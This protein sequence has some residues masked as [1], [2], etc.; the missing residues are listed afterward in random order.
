MIAFGISANLERPAVSQKKKVSFRD[1][2]DVLLYACVAHTSEQIPDV[3]VVEHA[4]DVAHIKCLPSISLHW[5]KTSHLSH[6]V[7]LS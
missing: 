6:H 7:Q 2:M 1:R 4:W 5:Q 3:R